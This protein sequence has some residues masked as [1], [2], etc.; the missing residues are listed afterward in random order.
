[1]TTRVFLVGA[2]QERNLY[3]IFGSDAKISAWSGNCK[4]LKFIKYLILF[5]KNNKLFIVGEKPIFNM[6]HFRFEWELQI[7]PTKE[8]WERK[9]IQKEFSPK[10]RKIKEQFNKK[11]LQIMERL[12]SLN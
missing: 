11:F 12:K 3:L 6:M 1:M 8:R 10:Y 9:A 5:Q 4:Y 7:F 2:I